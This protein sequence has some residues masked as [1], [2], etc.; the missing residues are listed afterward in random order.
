MEGIA[1]VLSGSGTPTVI[2]VGAPFRWA[3][4]VSG[5]EV[6]KCLEEAS[7]SPLLSD[8]HL[9]EFA[10]LRQ[11]A[12][13]YDSNTIEGIGLPAEDTIRILNEIAKRGAPLADFSF[14]TKHPEAKRSRQ[15]VVYHWLALKTLILLA[16]E[17]AA[18]ADVFISHDTVLQIHGI[19]LAGPNSPPSV[20]RTES[21]TNGA[22]HVY[23]S[24]RDVPSCFATMIQ[25]WNALWKSGIKG[26]Q[27]A[28]QVAYSFVALHPFLDGNGRMSR[29]LMNYA[30]KRSG[31][32]FTITIGAPSR[33]KH[34]MAAL[35]YADTREGP[36][37]LH[38]F[39]LLI[40]FGCFEA[41]TNY[42]TFCKPT[43]TLKEMSS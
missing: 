1:P 13:V 35:R 36:E 14:P 8:S 42:K 30:L 29:I 22:G 39:I 9:D 20:M 15:E 3:P 16:G 26:P 37:S 27:L 31:F 7:R 43:S 4:H 5:G 34:Y 17:P 6:Q 11:F 40:A 28:A 38:P 12:T 24:A 41:W 33:T 19:L 25:H 10:L 21:V 32:P 2:I 23:P 18:S